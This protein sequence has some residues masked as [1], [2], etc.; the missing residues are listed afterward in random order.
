MALALETEEREKLAKRTEEF[1]LEFA[2]KVEALH[3]QFE[4]IGRQPQSMG[5]PAPRVRASSSGPRTFFVP[6]RV[7]VYGFYGYEGNKGAL[8]RSE[9]EDLVAKLLD[10]VDEESKKGFKVEQRY[11]LARR[12]TFVTSDGGERCWILREQLLK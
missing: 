8:T 2:T 1:A 12:I 10:G 11:K 9:Q 5:G 3:K 4:E 7:F 6:H